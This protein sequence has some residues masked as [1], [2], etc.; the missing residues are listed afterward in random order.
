MSEDG[1]TAQEAEFETILA[2]LRDEVDRGEGDPGGE[3]G[4]DRYERRR[5]EAEQLWAVSAERPFLS[6]PGPYGRL[7]GLALTPLK[8]VLR[9]AM[10]WYV[11]PLAVDQRRFNAAALKLLDSVWERGDRQQAGARGAPPASR[12]RGRGRRAAHPARASRAGACRSGGRRLRVST[13]RDR[14]RRR[15][16]L[17]RLR[18]PDAR[19]DASAFATGS[20]RTW[21]TF[22]TPRP[23]STSAAAGASSSGSCARRASRRAAWTSTRTWSPTAAARAWT[24]SRQARSSTSRHSRTA[25]SAGSSPRRSWSTC[26]LPSSSACSSWPPPSCGPGGLLVAET[27]NP[28]SPI[29]LRNYFADLTH[30]QPLVPET[31]ELLARQ[32]GF[33]SVEVRFAERAGG[34]AR[35]AGGPDDRR[36]RPPPERA[37]VRAARLRHRRPHMRIAVCAPQVPFIRGGAEIVS[38]RLVEE[39]R[40]RDHDAELVTVPFKW[41]PGE[42]VLTQAFLWRLLDLEEAD[43]APIDLVIATKF[44]SYA[45]R[46]RE[47]GRLAPAPVPP[48]L[49]A[50][51][52]R[53]RPVRRVARGDGRCGARSTVSTGSRSARRSKLFATSRNVADRLER[54]TGLVA[55]GAAAPAAGAALPLRRVRR[56]RPLGRPHRPGQARRA[57]ARGARR[58]TRR[59]AA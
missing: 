3:R 14:S 46:H 59:C 33:A 43:G 34:A 36:E 31:L 29:A 55:G 56:L 22:A 26:R 23:C 28:L 9:K 13:E 27:I 18:E 10:R 38:D 25:R 20:G 12:A 24:S 48:G 30:A 11:E 52:H 51:P 47:Q 35:R 50:R 16:R 49:R 37:A 5:R 2:R 32:S 42:R 8:S 19:A 53:A 45:V 41:Y 40:K 1:L 15:A 4:V 17:L 44:P 54:S 6:R 7:R 39:L 58:A 57:A 21:T